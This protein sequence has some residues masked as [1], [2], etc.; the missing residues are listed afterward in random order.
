[1]WL[2]HAVALA[3]AACVT[4]V[5]FVVVGRWLLAQA[6]MEAKIRHH[7]LPEESICFA[8]YAANHQVADALAARLPVIRVREYAPDCYE[9]LY[10]GNP[11][12]PAYSFSVWSLATGSSA[13]MDAAGNTERYRPL[14]V[15]QARRSDG[16]L[17][18]QPAV[19][20]HNLRGRSGDLY[21]A[22]IAVH[23][24]ATGTVLASVLYLLSGTD[25]E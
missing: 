1:M 10:W 16:K 12:R 9:L 15:T 22:R 21:A 4:L 20:L 24:A 8:P 2:P 25:P 6:E 7:V 23:D 5:V 19:K 17:P 13:L 3:V 18:L 11:I 14:P